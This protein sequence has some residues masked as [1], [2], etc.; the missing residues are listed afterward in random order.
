MKYSFEIS[1]AI[2]DEKFSF[3]NDVFEYFDPSRYQFS[4]ALKHQSVDL[5]LIK[6]TSHVDYAGKSWKDLGAKM[7]QKDDRSMKRSWGN[8]LELQSNPTYYLN[9]EPKFGWALAKYEDHYYILS[10]GNHRSVIGRFFL[11]LNGCTPI[12]HGLD[13]SVYIDKDIGEKTELKLNFFHQILK[14]IKKKIF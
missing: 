11:E 13:V 3:Q 2:N 14:S 12:I 7:H 8:Y 4:H 1:K 5:S 6:G 10:D 9:H